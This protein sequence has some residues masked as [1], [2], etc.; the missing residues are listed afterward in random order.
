MHQHLA[1]VPFLVFV[2]APIALNIALWRR[3]RRPPLEATTA[4]WR[5][6]IS[7]LAVIANSLAI[8]LPWIVFLQAYLL[9][10]YRKHPIPGDALLNGELWLDISA[11][12]AAFS[13]LIA[14]VSPRGIR[15]LLVISGTMLICT[16]VIIPRGVL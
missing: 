6:Q 12:L 1:D 15:L 11:V 9:L 10:N 16:W 8:A 4:R 3:V 5:R 2:F 13:I 14:A 7:Y